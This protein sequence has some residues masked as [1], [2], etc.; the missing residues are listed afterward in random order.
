MD[1]RT[2]RTALKMA[3]M[4]LMMDITDFVIGRTVLNDKE[5]LKQCSC[6]CCN[7]LIECANDRQL[8]IGS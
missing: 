5:N 4:D 8:M 1:I 6:K 3:R 7:V 2:G